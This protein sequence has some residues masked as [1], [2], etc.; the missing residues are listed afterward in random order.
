MFVRFK[1]SCLIPEL[2]TIMTG[3][4]FYGHTKFDYSFINVSYQLSLIAL[5]QNHT[6][7][8]SLRQRHFRLSWQ[9]LYTLRYVEAFL[10]WL[11]TMNFPKLGLSLR[12]QHTITIC[13]VNR[14]PCGRTGLRGRGTLGKWG[15]NHAADP[16]VTRFVMTVFC[17]IYT[18]NLNHPWYC[19]NVIWN[20]M[21][22]GYWMICFLYHCKLVITL[23]HGE[24][25]I[26]WC[27]I[28]SKVKIRRR[29]WR[30]N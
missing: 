2:Y 28:C 27:R 11:W 3:T 14:N 13:F 19:T 6:K 8:L 25:F 16:V 15:P 5:A 4:L 21:S 23:R 1:S 20:A 9:E 30:S 24:F 10:L 26:T 18:E 17:S 22:Y 29:N 7:N 12:W